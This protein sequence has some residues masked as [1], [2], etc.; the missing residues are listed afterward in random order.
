MH[1]VI[2]FG[3]YNHFYLNEILCTIWTNIK[4]EIKRTALQHRLTITFYDFFSLHIAETHT[5]LIT[6]LPGRGRSVQQSH[7]CKT[8]LPEHPSSPV[9]SPPLWGAPVFWPGHSLP[10]HIWK[11]DRQHSI[12]NQQLII[13]RNCQVSQVKKLYNHIRT[14]FKVFLEL[15]A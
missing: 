6:V 1:I 15:N 12:V 4:W 2:V 11:T 14:L 13:S 7:R 8:H 5:H 3:H 10:C 9:T